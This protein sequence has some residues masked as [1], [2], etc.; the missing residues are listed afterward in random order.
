MGEVFGLINHPS[1][2]SL[3]QKVG[4]LQSY[5]SEQK[6]TLNGVSCPLRGCKKYTHSVV[7][8]LSYTCAFSLTYAGVF[9]A[10]IK[11]FLSY[12]VLLFKSSKTVA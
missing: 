2:H 11:H 10:N 12:E 3:L 9:L 7:Y 5:L 8:Y 1:S 6:A 4:W